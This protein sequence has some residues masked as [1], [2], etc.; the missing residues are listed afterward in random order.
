MS[1][2]SDDA[3]SLAKHWMTLSRSSFTSP[4]APKHRGIIVLPWNCERAFSNGSTTAAANMISSFLT[5]HLYWLTIS[6]ARRFAG[7]ICWLLWLY[8]VEQK[9]NVLISKIATADPSADLVAPL[10]LITCLPVG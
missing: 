5:L 8:L 1:P 2:S 6:R 7:L 9:L 4:I 10:A 3:A